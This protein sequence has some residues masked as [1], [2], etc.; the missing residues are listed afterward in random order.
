MSTNNK[1]KTTIKDKGISQIQWLR[2]C[3]ETIWTYSVATI[4]Y[5]LSYLF[6]F[7]FNA[8]PPQTMNLTMAR[9]SKVEDSKRFETNLI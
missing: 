6:S 9:L 2:L 5:F 7:V 3:P 1:F 4:M 8:P